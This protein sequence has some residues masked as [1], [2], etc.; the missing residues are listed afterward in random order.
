MKRYHGEDYA[1]ELTKQRLAKKELRKQQ[2]HAV[3][4]ARG[5]FSSKS[6]GSVG[7]DRTA[8]HTGL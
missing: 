7:A 1:A 5:L 2:A 4:V 8:A 6:M 3:E